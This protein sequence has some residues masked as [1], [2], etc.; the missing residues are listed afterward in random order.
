MLKLGVL[1][2]GSGTNLQAIIDECEKGKISAKVAVVISDKE[3]AY[4][5]IRAKKHHIPAILV[6]RKKF[7]HP[8]NYEKEILSYLKKHKV[9]LVI[10]AGYMRIVGKTIIEEYR[11]KIM[12]IHPALLPSFVGLS[13][14]KQAIDYG[15]KISGVTVHLV[16]EG[17]D[18]GPIILQEAVPVNNDDTPEILHHR[19][20][21]KEHQ[22]YPRA[23]QLFA[24]GKLKLEGRKVR[25]I[26]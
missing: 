23:I 15:V 7:S 20:Q 14:W 19:L 12:N 16:D 21:Q 24:E 13:A 6:D 22:I 17:M 26:D 25:I 3:D 4:A 1:A 10:L 18:T 5:L 9:D 2:S 8:N 11:N